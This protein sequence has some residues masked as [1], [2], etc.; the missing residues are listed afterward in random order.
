[1]ALRLYTEV[2]F[3]WA[4]HCVVDD[5]GTAKQLM[6]VAVL[7]CVVHHGVDTVVCIMYCLFFLIYHSIV[8]SAVALQLVTNR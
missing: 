4:Y 2:V 1:M 7:Q 8:L 3:C 6:F 5:I